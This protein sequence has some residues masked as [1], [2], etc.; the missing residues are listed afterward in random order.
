MVM[1]NERGFCI[2]FSFVLELNVTLELEM[3]LAKR[4]SSYTQSLTNW[5]CLQLNKFTNLS[6]ESLENNWKELI[7]MLKGKCDSLCKMSN[8]IMP[9]F[10]KTTN[11]KIFLKIDRMT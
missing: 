11:P 7:P 4:E 1:H 9:N 10:L 3:E 5:E 8:K 2:S 6:G